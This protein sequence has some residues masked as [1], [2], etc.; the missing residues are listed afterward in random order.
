MPVDDRADVGSRVV[1]GLVQ[2][3]LEMHVGREDAVGIVE[4]EL[5]DVVGLDL[6][7]CDALALDVDAAVL[8]ACADVPER[9]V[10]VALRREDARRP[11]NLLAQ[12]LLDHRQPRRS[13]GG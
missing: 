12:R 5:D 13:V 3:G 7:Q 10:R 11:G 2:H 1:D 8:A 4:R 9:E 6:V